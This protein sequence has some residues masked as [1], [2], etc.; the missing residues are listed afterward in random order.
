Q[1]AGFGLDATYAPAHDANAVDHGGV[2]VGAD[3]RIGIVD[4]VGITVHTTCQVLQVDLVN[5][6]KAGRD[7]T[8]RIKRLHTPFHELIAFTIALEFDLHVQVQR[9]VCAVVIDHD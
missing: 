1:H 9:I 7:Y 4:V 2:A 8:E 5:D 6:T 3:Q